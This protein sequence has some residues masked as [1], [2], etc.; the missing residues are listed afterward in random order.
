[1]VCPGGNNHFQTRLEFFQ[2]TRYILIFQSTENQYNRCIRKIF[3]KRLP[4]MPSR[5][6]VVCRIDDNWR[7]PSE[8]F[9]AGM[10]FYLRKSFLDG[11][12]GNWDPTGFEGGVSHGGIFDLVGAEQGY[13]KVQGRM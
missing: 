2:H 11:W 8:N 13:S 10:R 12:V 5:I 4:E 7:V 9:K 1:M 6:A 3:V